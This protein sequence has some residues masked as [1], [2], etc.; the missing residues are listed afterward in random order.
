M[1]DDSFSAVKHA[2]AFL[3]LFLRICNDAISE[4]F[5]WMYPG[6]YQPLQAMSLLLADLLQ[7]PYSD[8]AS[9]SR[10]LIDACF[11]TYQ[12]DEGVVSQSDSPRRQLSSL[13]KDAWS[14][15]V[16]TRKKA[17]DL[18]GQDHHVLLPSHMASSDF[19]MCGQ[20]IVRLQVGGRD[21][22]GSQTQ[23]RDTAPSPRNTYELTEGQDLTPAQMIMGN[24]D[25]D[26]DMWDASV[27]QLPGFMS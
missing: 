10:G 5:H 3:Q 15:L 12:V 14:M 9:L 16:R 8:E 23:W 21:K 6:I 27:G 18:I 25:F 4:P 1:T 7:R 19:C 20:R 22:D 17:L 24:I 2:Q 11:G 13:G 26:W